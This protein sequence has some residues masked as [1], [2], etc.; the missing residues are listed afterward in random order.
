MKVTGFHPEARGVEVA[1]AVARQFGKF[2]EVDTFM[3][4]LTERSR[5]TGDDERGGLVVQVRDG[6][7][8]VQGAAQMA[9]ADALV[10]V[11]QEPRS[12]RGAAI[13]HAEAATWSGGGDHG[14]ITDPRVN[15]YVDLGGLVVRHSS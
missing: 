12:A 7:R 13:G 2:Y 10:R 6:L 14:L 5:R 15:L 3:E 9:Q 11:E 4:L 8:Q 1:V